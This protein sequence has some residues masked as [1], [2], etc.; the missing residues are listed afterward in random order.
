MGTLGRNHA[1]EGQY[2]KEE[3]GRKS[4]CGA[5]IDLDQVTVLPFRMHSILHE[6]S[7]RIQFRVSITAVA[8]DQEPTAE[9]AIQASAIQGRTKI[10]LSTQLCS[11][12]E[13]A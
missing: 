6:L 5:E 13:L 12:G 3:N 8:S 4:H 1:S 10:R 2:G 11:A 9:W 7:A